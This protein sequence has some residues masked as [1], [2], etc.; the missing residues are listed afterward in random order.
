LTQR[1]RGEYLPD[2]MGGRSANAAAIVV[3]VL[4]LLGYVLFEGLVSGLALF[5]AGV[6]LVAVGIWTLQDRE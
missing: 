6:V 5:V 2:G 3:A 4:G 1:V